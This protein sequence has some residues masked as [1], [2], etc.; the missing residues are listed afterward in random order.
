MHLQHMKGRRCAFRSQ[1]FD[2]PLCS[3]TTVCDWQS[4]AKPASMHRTPFILGLLCGLSSDVSFF[5]FGVFI[6]N[7]LHFWAFFPARALCLKYAVGLCVAIWRQS[8][9]SVVVGKHT[10][11]VKNGQGATPGMGIG[12]SPLNRSRHSCLQ[13][14]VELYIITKKVPEA[15][16]KTLIQNWAKNIQA[17]RDNSKLPKIY[18]LTH[19]LGNDEY[20]RC[21]LLCCC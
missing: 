6:F 20:G 3:T 18:I 7:F 9:H 19:R 10:R 2:P 17:G 4:S 14:N 16:F 21:V 5:F 1:F 12:I 11:P 15:N 13:D 8:D